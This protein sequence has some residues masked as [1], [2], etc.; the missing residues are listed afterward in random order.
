QF[1]FSKGVAAVEDDI[2]IL[3]ERTRLNQQWHMI[4]GRILAFA[5]AQFRATPLD[6]RPRQNLLDPWVTSGI[7]EQDEIV[8]AQVLLRAVLVIL[9]GWLATEITMPLVS[10]PFQT[11]I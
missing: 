9:D 8:A 5:Q 6:R 3:G 7:A 2:A 10:E 4:G 11:E 1:L